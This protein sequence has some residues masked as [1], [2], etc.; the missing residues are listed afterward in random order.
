[1]SEKPNVLHISTHDSGRFFGCYGVDTVATP[2][3]D[4]LAAE[5]VLA[6]QMHAVCP[7]CSPSRGAAMTGLYPQRNGLIGLTHQG[8]SFN[9]DTVHLA[10][11]MREGGYET[12]L[13]SF[14][15]EVVPE[16][17]QRLGFEH[18][19]C[20]ETPDMPYP[21][22][23][24]PA[25]EVAQSFAGWI[26]KRKEERPFYVQLGF[27]ETHTPFFFGGVYPDKSRGVTVPPYIAD[28]A[29]GR[30]Y[31]AHLQGAIQQVDEAVGILME[32]LQA[33]GLA[34]NTIVIFT[35]DHG[36][37]A[38]RAKWTLYDPGTGIAFI[39]RWPEGGIAGGRRL[40]RLESNI[41]FT[42][43]LLELCGL[44]VPEGLDGTSRAGWLTGSDADSPFRDPFFGIY[45][46]GSSRCIRTDRYK[47]IRN[48]GTEI[49]RYEYPCKMGAPRVIGPAVFCE[50]Y[51]LQADPEEIH[52]L[53]D[54]PDHARIRGELDRQLKIWLEKM[55]DPILHGPEPSPFYTAALR[56]FIGN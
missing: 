53:A 15:H 54:D 6:G 49:E 41:H 46:N 25:P 55:A 36:I 1:M 29:A 34:E 48:F 50:L 51:D 21:Y 18:Y 13:F 31:F 45:H 40:R 11:R 23:F 12:T 33:N 56:N 19:A 37:E 42:P 20:R 9:D 35:T 39:A 3:I 44:P 43:T 17:W 24:R 26:G 5:G 30:D 7:I 16:N 27:N 14:Q 8:Y 47:L 2:N 4:K 28:D 32:A 22:M 52:N 38:R 10:Q